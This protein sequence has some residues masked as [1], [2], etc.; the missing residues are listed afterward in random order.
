[1]LGFFKKIFDHEYKELNRF[2]LIADQVFELEEQYKKMSDD[3][4]KKVTD[5]LKKRLDD[6]EEL[7]SLISKCIMLVV[8]IM[9]M[10]Y[11]VVYLR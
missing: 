6:G 1:M 5:K 9:L 4:L 2:K 8:L 7:D 3:K 11:L 10:E